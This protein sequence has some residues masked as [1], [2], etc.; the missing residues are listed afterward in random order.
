MYNRGCVVT[1]ASSVRAA[2][3]SRGSFWT[4]LFV[5]VTRVVTVDLVH[6]SGRSISVVAAVNGGCAARVSPPHSYARAKAK[7]R[8]ALFRHE[9]AQYYVSYFG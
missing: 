7:P 3:L 5:I 4:Y 8:C 9:R 1:T 2:T 6:Y